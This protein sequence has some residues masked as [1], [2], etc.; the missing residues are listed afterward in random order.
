VAQL[1]A[2]GFDAEAIPGGKGQFDIVVDGE[3]VFSKQELGRF[4]EDGEVLALL[5]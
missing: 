5:R 2:E 1:A 3:P 4:P